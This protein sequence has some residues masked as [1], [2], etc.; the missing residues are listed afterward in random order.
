MIVN[1]PSKGLEF[2]SVY[3]IDLINGDIP[4]SINIDLYEMEF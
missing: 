1:H 3:M 4:S 2:D